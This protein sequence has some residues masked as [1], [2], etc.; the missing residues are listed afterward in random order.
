MFWRGPHYKGGREGGKRSPS[1]R[2]SE[3]KGPESG[4]R[5]ASPV[6][7]KAREGVELWTRERVKDD[8]IR[9]VK[10]RPDLGGEL[11]LCAACG[12]KLLEGPSKEVSQL[13]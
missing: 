6:H 3:C 10:W 4:I 7:K 1:K 9:E 8:G 2:K 13:Y 5:L 12:G 11:G